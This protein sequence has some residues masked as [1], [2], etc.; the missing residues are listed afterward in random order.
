MKLIEHLTDI[1]VALWIAEDIN[2][3]SLPSENLLR[4]LARHVEQIR[5]GRA[6][7]FER[8][9]RERDE[10]RDVAFRAAFAPEEGATTKWGLRYAN[11]ALCWCADEADARE[12]FAATAAPNT[13]LVR[14]T[15]GPWKPVSPGG[16]A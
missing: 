4:I 11:G 12:V 9:T 14:C 1:E 15:V 10:A 16:E 7:A 5:A 3:R 2:Y 6:D 8:L 13:D